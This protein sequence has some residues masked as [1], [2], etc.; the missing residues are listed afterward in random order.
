MAVAAQIS[1]VD[2]GESSRWETWKEHL[3]VNRLP[4]VVFAMGL[5]FFAL[6]ALSKSPAVDY[7]GPGAVH[8]AKPVVKPGENTYIVFENVTW[9]RLCPAYLKTWLVPPAGLRNATAIDLPRHDISPPMEPGPIA[10]KRR[11]WHVPEN[12]EPGQWKMEGYVSATCT[13]LWFI[14]LDPVYTPLPS[15]PLTIAD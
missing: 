8:L 3:T 2:I 1:G 7:G 11:P 13:W 10:S 4:I 5:M 14:Q 6:G 9:R 15:V 12:L